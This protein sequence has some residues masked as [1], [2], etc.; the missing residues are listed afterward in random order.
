MK[1]VFPWWKNA[2]SGYQIFLIIRSNLR[3]EQMRSV[4]SGGLQFLWYNTDI[5]Q[6][7]SRKRM[8]SV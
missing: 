4:F 5:K 2:V 3:E 8:D 7:I 1:T 6:E